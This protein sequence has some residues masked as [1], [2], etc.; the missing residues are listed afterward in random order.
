MCKHVPQRLQQPPYYTTFW[1][2]MVIYVFLNYQRENLNS[3]VFITHQLTWMKTYKFIAVYLDGDVYLTVTQKVHGRT[4]IAEILTGGIRTRSPSK[5]AAA[6]PRLRLRDH[7][8]QQ[9]LGIYMHTLKC[10]L[11]ELKF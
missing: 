7:W 6:D 3:Y 8:N 9:E 1:F 5:R 4:V 11:K 10:L 2:K